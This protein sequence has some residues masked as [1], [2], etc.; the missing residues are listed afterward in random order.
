[1]IETDIAHVCSVMMCSGEVQNPRKVIP[2]AARSIYLRLGLFYILGTLAL[3]VICDSNNPEL[4]AA[5][6]N[7]GT[8]SA[9]SPW[10][11]GLKAL[12]I[13]GLANLVN[14]IVLTSA[15]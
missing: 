5:L 3:G 9:A 6:E 12:G 11:I 10:V 7:G 13:N 4:L 14:A 15:W 2:M 1:M 8:G